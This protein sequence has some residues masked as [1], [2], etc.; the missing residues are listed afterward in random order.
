MVRPEGE[1]LTEK[2]RMEMLSE[3][4]NSQEFLP[5][6]QY[7]LSAFERR[8]LAYAMTCSWPSSLTCERTAPILLSLAS[9]CVKDERSCKV[10][11]GQDWC[12]CQPMVQLFKCCLA[13]IHPV[14]FWFLVI[15]TTIYC[16]NVLKVAD[17]L[18]PLSF[19]SVRLGQHRWFLHHR[20]SL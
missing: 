9:I 7:C 20:L 19:T 5:N 6:N 12:R 10:G 17:P 14:E 4:H 2:L 3:G 15:I 13:S 8:R 18:A 11:E 16:S 1:V